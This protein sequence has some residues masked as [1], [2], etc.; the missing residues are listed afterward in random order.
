[1]ADD[2][3]KDEL[4][5]KVE[6]DNTE[7]QE[8]FVSPG[9]SG[10]S[11]GVLSKIASVFKKKPQE[12]VVEDTIEVVDDTVEVDKTGEVDD[13]TEDTETKEDK[14][15]YE[16]IDPK[17]IEVA[18][19]YGW[20]DSRII[21]YAENHSEEDLVILNNLMQDN[22][23]KSVSKDDKTDVVSDDVNTDELLKLAGDDPK[24]IALVKKAIGPL[25]KRVA[26]FS[27]DSEKLTK[28]LGE[29][30]QSDLL[31]EELRNLDA[32]N[33]MFDASGISSLGKTENIPK[34]PDGSFVQNDPAFQ[35]R[36]KVWDIAQMFYANGGTFKEA[37]DN[38][39][40][41]YKGNNAEKDIKNKVIKD[42]KKQE[43]RVMPKR[44]ESKGEVVYVNDE[45]RKAA[46]VNAALSKY[47]KELPTT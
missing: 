4:E 26:D 2:E 13:T 17:F 44:T 22:I 12:E 23:N 37:V 45:E 7:E 43:E 30:K 31:K 36:S 6:E 21:D 29:Q 24:L 16:E 32:A 10:P 18:R 8:Q 1:M 5:N 39:V 3:K 14:D 27:S 34:Y 19:K 41:W 11:E 46:I 20:D 42:L 40:Q 33:S 9:V 35:E 38:A 15:K 28:E 47:N 25:A